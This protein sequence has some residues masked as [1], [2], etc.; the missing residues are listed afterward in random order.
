MDHVEILMLLYDS[1][2]RDFTAEDAAAQLHFDPQSTARIM[3]ALVATGFLSANR[4]EESGSGTGAHASDGNTR[5][6]YQPSTTAI[7]SATDALAI[8]FH[9]RPIQLVTAVCSRPTTALMTFADAF[10]LRNRKE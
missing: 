2:D 6:S 8:E 7:A 10:R 5:Y 4:D 1:P 3:R 9:Q